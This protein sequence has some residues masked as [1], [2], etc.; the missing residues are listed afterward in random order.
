MP[1]CRTG[2]VTGF[3]AVVFARSDD[4][5]CF[6]PKEWTMQEVVPQESWSHHFNDADRDSQLKQVLDNL[7]TEN[8]QLKSLVIRLSETI[9]RNVTSKR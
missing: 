1:P 6:E 5:G 7:Q 9:I 2:R 4:D 3:T 8:S